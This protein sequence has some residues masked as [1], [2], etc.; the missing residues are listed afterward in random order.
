MG[1]EKNKTK[2]VLFEN[3][4]NC[5]QRKSSFKKVYF[6]S[7]KSWQTFAM[8]GHVVNILGSVG[9]TISATTT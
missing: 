3:A 5:S 8:K 6:K 1:K 9:H 4:F 2:K 7:N